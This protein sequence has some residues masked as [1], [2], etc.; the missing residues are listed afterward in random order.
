MY[1]LK[2]THK[3][4]NQSFMIFWEALQ[5]EEVVSQL[6]TFHM[7]LNPPTHSWAG[8]TINQLRAHSH[9]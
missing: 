6:H 1:L 5:F 9:V 8:S 3:F 7:D 2:S 4:C